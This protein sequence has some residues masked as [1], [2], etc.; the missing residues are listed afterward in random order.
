MPTLEFFHVMFFV[1]VRINPS[2]TATFEVAFTTFKGNFIT[3]SYT[4]R[5]H[6]CIFIFTVTVSAAMFTPFTVQN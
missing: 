1:H 4:F 2:T 3:H 6:F 5:C